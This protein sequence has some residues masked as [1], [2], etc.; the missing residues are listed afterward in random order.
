MEEQDT[1]VLHLTAK[2]I[3]IKTG[4]WTVENEAN[5]A[6]GQHENNPS[7][8]VQLQEF[9]L[10]LTQTSAVLQLHVG[11]LFSTPELWSCEILL[12]YIMKHYMIDRAL[13]KPY[14]KYWPSDIFWEI[15][16]EA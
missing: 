15:Y 2:Y 4:C 5:Q 8:P 1:A 7:S 16:H 10:S 13:M 11:P 6:A 3:Q 12:K 14:K 9:P